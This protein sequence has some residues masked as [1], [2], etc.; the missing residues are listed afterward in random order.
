MVAPLSA[1]QRS[2]GGPHPLYRSSGTWAARGGAPD[3]RE[4]LGALYELND[5]R[6]G[7]LRTVLQDT[8]QV[9]N[10]V[11]IEPL[12][13]KGAIALLPDP[14]PHAGARVL[15]DLDV[16]V[17]PAQIAPA[18]A[19]LE[20]AGYFPAPNIYAAAW[21]LHDHHHWFPLYHPSGDGYVELH[22]DLFHAPRLKAAL[23]QPLVWA[24]AE[25]CDWVG[26]R[27]H[28]PAL[29][30]R[31]LHNA[32]H[33]QVQDRGFPSDRRSLRQLLEF[34]HL[35]ALPT[36]VALDW[37]ELFVQLD[38]VGVGDA[39]RAWLLA[40]QGLFGQPLPTGV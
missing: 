26:L 11:G 7:R 15:G 32:L 23:S 9:L 34:A 37:P 8:V 33:H 27:V 30:H 22:H 17:D 4:A 5:Q 14:Y 24:R 18:V 25:A 13:L 1:G 6:N 40:A 39:V 38:K 35:R 10:A 21:S 28:I 36:A 20:A 12:L 31:L 29:E 19:A 3:R 2:S 16:A